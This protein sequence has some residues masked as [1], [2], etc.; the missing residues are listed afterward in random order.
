MD[1]YAAVLSRYAD[2]YLLWGL[3][4]GWLYYRAQQ[5]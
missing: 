5:A 3:L 1:I 4:S 2:V